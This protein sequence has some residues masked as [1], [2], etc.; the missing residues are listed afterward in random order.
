MKATLEFNLPEE[1]DEHRVAVQGMDW[2][3]L[4][5]EVDQK[6]RDTVKYGDSEQ[7]ADYAEKIRDYIYEGMGDRG[8][9]WSP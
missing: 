9:T 2:Q 7:L 1:S 4:L 6:L 3:M 5:F 8:L